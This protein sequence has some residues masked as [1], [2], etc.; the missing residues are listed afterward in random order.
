MSHPLPLSVVIPTI[1][2]PELLAGLLDSISAC[3]PGPE[4]VLIV[5]QS[6]GSEV[7]D[8]AARYAR[9][10]IVTCPGRGEALARNAGLREAARDV[11]LWTDDDCSVADDWVLRAWAHMQGNDPGLV[12]GRVL[13]GGGGTVG[14]GPG[15]VPSTKD[16][17][18]PHEFTGELSSGAL[19][20]PCMAMDRREA[21]SLG[22]FDERLP[23]AVDNDFAYRWLRS[24]R[25][26]RYEPDMVVWHND[27][28]DPTQLKGLY[29]SYAR[30]Q[31]QFYAKHLRTGDLNML[32]FIG[33]DAVDVCIGLAQLASKGAAGWSNYRRG[34]LLGLLPGMAEGWRI[35]NPRRAG[36]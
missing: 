26:M 13:P 27:W 23:T 8:V 21:I 14:G 33:R 2:R 18:F 15:G 6:G 36:R 30:G 5:D 1:G 22:G 16:D 35:F 7:A 31:G 29:I 11:T 20:P 32:R 10:R 25:R 19:Y 9:A 34:L 24:G 17:P 4:E 12:T 28:R 3:D